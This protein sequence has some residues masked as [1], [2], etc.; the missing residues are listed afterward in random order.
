MPSAKQNTATGQ[1]LIAE[2]RR[3]DKCLREAQD[4]QDAIDDLKDASE[5]TWGEILSLVGL[6]LTVVGAIVAAFFGDGPGA[7]AGAITIGGAGT[8]AYGILLNV[9][10]RIN[11][12]NKKLERAIQRLRDCLS[13]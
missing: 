4:V 7:I 8:V 12:A 2:A 11:K 1:Q 10:A 9:Y 6:G 13:R 5:L 3:R